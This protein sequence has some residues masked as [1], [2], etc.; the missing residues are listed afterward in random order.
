M[1]IPIPCSSGSDCDY[2]DAHCKHGVPFDDD[3]SVDCE[4]CEF[5]ELAAKLNANDGMEDV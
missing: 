3:L 4:D 5:E 2:R 1:A